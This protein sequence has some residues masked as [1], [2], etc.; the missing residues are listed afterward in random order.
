VTLDVAL[1]VTDA[2]A[3]AFALGSAI[4]TSGTDIGGTLLGFVGIPGW[5]IQGIDAVGFRGR[6]NAFAGALMTA[7]AG[8][9]PASLVEITLFGSLKYGLHY[10]IIWE[11]E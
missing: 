6:L 4:T 2:Q 8:A 3:I 11:E 10:D 1:V 7:G 9:A 5:I